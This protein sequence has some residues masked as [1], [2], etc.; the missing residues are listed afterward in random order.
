MNYIKVSEGQYY[1]LL[2]KDSKLI[3]A[4]IIEYVLYLRKI[5][6]LAPA[7]ITS[8]LAA[9][10]HYFDINEI[11]LKWKKIN[12]FKGERYTVVEDRP[13]T[14]EEI[15]QLLDKIDLQRNRAILLLLT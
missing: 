4:E 15:K 14:R 12:S 6:K 2:A 3:Q 11:E 8:Y 10:R 9:V 13:Y 7:T 5:R 1:K